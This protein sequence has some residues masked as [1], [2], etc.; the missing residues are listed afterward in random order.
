MT[1]KSVDPKELPATERKRALKVIDGVAES[2]KTGT[3]G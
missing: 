1:L 3:D 2:F